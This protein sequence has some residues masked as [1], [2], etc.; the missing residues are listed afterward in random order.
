MKR[1]DLQLT[2]VVGEDGVRH[3]TLPDDVRAYIVDFI[4]EGAAK[5]P[6]DIAAIVQEGH[7]E[8]HAALDGLSDQQARH[9]PGADDW[10]V[11][12]VMD[13]VVTVKRL[14]AQLC[15]HLSE[16]RWPPGVTGEFQE[17]AAQDGVTLARFTSLDEAR[18]AADEAH[19]GLLGFIRSIT[20][21]TSTEKEFRHFVFGS[22]NCRQ[23]AVFQRI[24]DADHAPAIG[25]IRVTPGFPA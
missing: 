21:A 17:E 25:R 8:L 2:Y 7:D 20:P 6:H 22:M 16:G 10:C 13:H 19:A 5:E 18:Q 15:Q 14:M 1:M 11:L 24:H 3:L 12:E 9:K 4:R 23:W